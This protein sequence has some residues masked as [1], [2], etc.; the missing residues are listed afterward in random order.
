MA[1]KIEL[2]SSLFSILKKEGFN[3]FTVLELRGAYL[4]ISGNNNLHKVEARRFV[5]RHILRLEKKGLLKRTH[6]KNTNK[7]SYVKTPLFEI[8]KLD[9]KD[10]DLD[11][12]A[13]T[14]QEEN[15]LPSKDLIRGMVNKL[16]NY[17]V[18]L[19]TSIG[20]TDEY[21]ALCLE[22]PQLKDQ[23]QDSY[24]RARDNSQKIIGKVKAL[25]SF[26]AQ[27]KQGQQSL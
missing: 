2:D 21:K 24:N 23:L 7:T 15:N 13:V 20:E 16:Q 1:K 27:Q 26:I 11:N 19:L 14:S 8:S 25:E 9:V 4:A 22:Y 3:N 18:E 17:K 10:D 12:D 6:S 5:Y